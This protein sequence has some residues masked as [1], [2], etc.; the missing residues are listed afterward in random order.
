MTTRSFLNYHHNADVFT[1]T[2]KTNPAGQRVF[3]YTKSKTI[4]VI[5]RSA[6]SERRIAPYIEGIDDAQLYVP[7]FHQQDIT[8]DIRIGNIRDRYGNV[9][10]DNTFEVTQ[11]EKKT[12]FNGKVH[13]LVV[14]I[15][16]VAEK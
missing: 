10:I 3:S 11:I 5:F 16:K 15:K 12:S 13:H 7:F 2:T 4:P 1:R 14:S 8:Y 9:I 6:S